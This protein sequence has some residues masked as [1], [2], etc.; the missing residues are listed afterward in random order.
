VSRIYDI[1]F[2]FSQIAIRGELPTERTMFDNL[3]RQVKLADQLGF[4]TAWIGGAHLSLEEQHRSGE[5]PVLPHFEGEVCL[6]TDIL[7]LSHLLM[8]HTSRID[9]GSALHS[10][11]VNGGPIAHAEAVRTF[12]TLKEMSPAS[13]RKLRL[14]FG[15]GRFSFV[16]EAYGLVPR[17]EVERV[18]WPV[19]RGLLL[20]QA[21]EIFVRM[22]D[23]EALAS[24]DL[25]AQEL[26]RENFRDEEHWQ[27]VVRAHGKET[28]S[29][30]IPEFFRFDRL[31]LVPKE[32]PLETLRLYL[33][34]TDI[35]TAVRINRFHPCRIFNLS[36]TSAEAIDSTHQQMSKIYHPDGGPWKREYMPRTVMV[37][38]DASEDL[39]RQQRNER[40]RSNAIDALRAWQLSMEGTVDE[41]KLPQRLNNA[42]H[43]SPEDVADQ[44][45]KMFHPDDT[46]MLWFDFNNHDSDAVERNMVAFVEEV[47]PR[48]D[49]GGSEG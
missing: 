18:A 34:S 23:G 15:S 8:S 21:A 20:R 17:N 13:D 47:L 3:L 45:E 37:F 35:E 49:P 16:Q 46:L 11:L 2:G 41:G 22:V 44:I 39:N 43:G 27:T 9:F 38:T 30:E 36:S 1:F 40:A 26:R 4:R 32:S 14:G 7:Q 5:I 19:I 10:I 33:G 48:L 25:P 42:V 24:S 6:N 31:R 12:L 29:I 28:D